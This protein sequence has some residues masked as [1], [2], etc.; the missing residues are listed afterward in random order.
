MLIK[1]F[2]T[3]MAMSNNRRFLTTLSKIAPHAIPKSKN[4]FLFSYLSFFNLF[5]NISF[6]APWN[7]EIG[8]CLEI[9][10]I[11]TSPLIPSL[12]HIPTSP[13]FIVYF[14]GSLGVSVYLHHIFSPSFPI[15]AMLISYLPTF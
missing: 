1:C 10:Q 6:H 3:K 9:Y 12:F 4:F 14:L 5:L 15:N 11:Y 8:F 13:T 7:L 2:H